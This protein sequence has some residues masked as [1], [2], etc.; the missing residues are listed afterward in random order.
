MASTVPWQQA[1]AHPARWLRAMLAGWWR[2][3]H[4]G[5]VML[6]LALTPSSYRRANRRILAHHVYVD[7]APLLPGFT[8]LSALVSVVLIRIVVVTAVSYGLTR[9]A[10]EM[11]VRV[12][13][14]ELIPLTAALFAAMRCTVPNGV[15]IAALRS[16]GRFEALRAAGA[17]P[18]R[19]EVLPR[20]ASGVF[21]VL[22][23]AAVSCVVAL[24]LAYLS[25]YGFTSAAMDS[26]TRTVGHVFAP[27][28]SLIFVLKTVLFGLVV[29]LIPAA[30]A[31]HVRPHA[32]ARTSAEMQ[33][34]VRMLVMIL[35]IEVA[36]LVGNYS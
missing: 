8:V 36:S 19:V 20:V 26:Y 6:A 30:A 28:V 23:L 12:L 29:A 2:V 16:G 25:V 27:A 3:A 7:T 14:L 15:E 32:R 11:V 34:L 21:A 4:L 33:A 22:T 9:Y 10:L 13:V 24:V 35:L 18:L 1:L 17:D 31:L 5:A